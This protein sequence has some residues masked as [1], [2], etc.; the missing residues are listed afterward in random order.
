MSFRPWIII[1]KLSSMSDKASWN[2]YLKHMNLVGCHERV[3]H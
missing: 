1:S 2:I 3:S